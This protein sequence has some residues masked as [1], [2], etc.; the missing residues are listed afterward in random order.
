LTPKITVD[1]E[2]Y[3]PSDDTFLITDHLSIRERDYVLDMGTGTGILAIKAA[4]LG[5]RRVLAV[6]INPNASRCALR[7]TKLNGLG[8]QISLLT[9]DL[10]H[11]LREGML[12]DV[13]VFNPPY[14][15]TKESE[16][17]RGWLERSWA[18]GPNGM[19]VLD[20]FIPRLPMYLKAS[21]QLFILHPSYG[22][23]ATIRKLKE[24]GMS[25]SIVASKKLFFENLLV[26]VARFDKA[27]RLM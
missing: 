8:D 16:R 1:E 4:L 10:F 9:G 12:F 24:M 11:S 20:R 27:S 18:G 2:V 3:S 21:G 19:A 15:Q 7:N 26:L 5:A 25:V 6:D 14:L 22:L 17:R 23:R 13:I